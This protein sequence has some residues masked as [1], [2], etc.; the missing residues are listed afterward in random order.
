M[1][2]ELKTEAGRRAE[3]EKKIA[4]LEKN[5]DRAAEENAGLRQ[6]IEEHESAWADARDR[7]QEDLK[8][9][10]AKFDKLAAFVTEMVTSLFGKYFYCRLSFLFFLQSVRLNPFAEFSGGWSHICKLEPETK[11]RAV[12]TLVQ[13]LYYGAGKAMM[14]CHGWEKPPTTQLKFLEAL[15]MLPGWIESWK[16]SSAR[17]S[18]MRVLALAKSYYPAL[19]TAVLIR[20]WPSL[21]SDGSPFTKEDLAAIDDSI[22]HHCTVLTDKMSLSSFQPCFSAD[23]KKTVPEGSGYHEDGSQLPSAS[24]D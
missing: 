18:A 13:Q 4:E 15:N 6:E 24:S 23:G 11:L 10:N 20:G 5:L 2:E 7:L 21:K 16:R 22:R 9:S 8:A 1:K 3:L 14:A 12:C 19:D 17:R